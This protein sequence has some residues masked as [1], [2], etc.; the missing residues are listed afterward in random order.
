LPVPPPF[1]FPRPVFSRPVV[2][3]ALVDIASS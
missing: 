2:D 1:F 3:P